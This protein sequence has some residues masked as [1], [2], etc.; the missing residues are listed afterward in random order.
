MMGAVTYEECPRGG[1]TG[2]RGCLCGYCS[3]CGWAKHTAI[4]GPVM[5]QGPGSTPVGHEY[6]DAVEGGR[7]V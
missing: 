6:A 4:H 3:T 1:G 2:T 7:N 5:G